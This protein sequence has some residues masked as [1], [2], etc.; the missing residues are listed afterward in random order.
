M[1]ISGFTTS[2]R[3]VDP[4]RVVVIMPAFNEQEALPS[5]LAGLRATSL[6]LDIVVVDDGSTDDTAAIAI[7]GQPSSRAFFSSCSTRCRSEKKKCFG[8]E[9]ISP[10]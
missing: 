1:S 6:P 4:D 9:G 2:A 5:T 8:P 3:G 7:A 10:H